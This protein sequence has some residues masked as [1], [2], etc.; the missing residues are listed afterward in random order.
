[1]FDTHAPTPNLPS[2]PAT[3][4]CPA[5]PF[6]PL[7]DGCVMCSGEQNAAR[8]RRQTGT[9]NGKPKFVMNVPGRAYGM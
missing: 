8:D 5:H 1:M 4:S 3:E 6:A 7:R 9:K 2:N